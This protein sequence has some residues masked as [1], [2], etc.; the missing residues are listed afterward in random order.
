MS[1]KSSFSKPDV[2]DRLTDAFITHGYG[3]T[4]LAL[5]QEATGLGRQSLYNTFGD[6]QSM[7]LEALACATRRS[8]HAA[9][10]MRAAPNGRAAL[11]DYFGAIVAYCSSTD[12]TLRNCI[13]TS[14]LLEALDEASIA[15]TLAELWRA[16]F[17]FLQL[18]VERGQRDGSI[19]NPAPP[20]E[21][22]E[23][24]CALVSGL[25]VAGRVG[26]S[27]AQMDRLV[28]HTL[29]ILDMA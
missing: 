1:R 9:A 20:G 28:M 29:G 4:S 15:Q 2:L 22:T 6:K 12:A 7:Y 14:G 13:G 19:A 26:R 23:V 5:L 21:L 24:I 25:R 17:A 10:L 16:N 11:R 3:G 18:A 8:A 27:R